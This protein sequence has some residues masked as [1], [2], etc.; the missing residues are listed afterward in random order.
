MAVVGSFHQQIESL[1]FSRANLAVA[2]SNLTGNFWNGYVYLMTLTEEGFKKAQVAEFPTCL[3]K[4]AWYGERLLLGGDDGALRVLNIQLRTIEEKQEFDNCITDLQVTDSKIVVSDRASIK[5]F[6]PDL[7]PGNFWPV[8]DTRTCHLFE[9]SLVSGHDDGTWRLWDLREDI[10]AITEDTNK[11]PVRSVA[12][13]EYMIYIAR[14]TGQIEGFDCRT[15]KPYL[16]IV[17]SS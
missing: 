12:N 6:L 9:N 2:A 13:H 7:R 10:P 14:E 8:K 5:T 1:S 16:S 11:E 15:N 3:P 4:V 17:T